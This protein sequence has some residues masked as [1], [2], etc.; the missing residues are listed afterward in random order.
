MLKLAL[1]VNRASLAQGGVTTLAAPPPDMVD[2]HF[3]LGALRVHVGIVL[4][5][6]EVNPWVQ[7]IP[8][9]EVGVRVVDIVLDNHFSN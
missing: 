2:Y 7:G 6:G 9:L 3:S 4:G 5:Q 1:I 8:L